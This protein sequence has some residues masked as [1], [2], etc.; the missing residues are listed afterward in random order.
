V[1]LLALRIVQGF[2]LGG[3]YGSAVVYVME[4]APETA[5]GRSTSVL[6]ATASVGLLLALVIVSAL[7]AGLTPEHFDGWGWRVP[8]LLSAPIVLVAAWIRLGM[9]ESPVFARLQRAGETSKSPLADTVRS[10]SSWRM[11]LLAIF[12][13]QGATS[14]LLYTSIVYMIY[15]LQNVLHVDA[16]HADLCLALAIV[17][18]APFYPTFGALSDRIGRSRVMLLGTTTWLAVAYPVFAAIEAAASAAAWP[19][20]TALISVLSVLTA[21]VMAPLP[22]YIS[23]CFPART[24]TTG[25]GLAQQ[26]GNIIFGGFLPLISLSLV[27]WSGNSLAGVAYSMAS[28]VPCVLAMYLWGLKQDREFRV[29]REQGSLSAAS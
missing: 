3:E 8:F 6:Q 12:S 18:A 4:H 14:V 24:R 9:L 11:I 20:V 15:F 2:A 23:E 5:R 10:A 27:R 7:K 26:I 1:L 16:L 29:L 19:K 28:L 13:A 25:F 17:V 21:M 22:A